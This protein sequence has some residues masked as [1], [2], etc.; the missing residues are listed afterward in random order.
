MPRLTYWAISRTPA[1]RLLRAPDPWR[2][3]RAGT[4]HPRVGVPTI[5]LGLLTLAGTLGALAAL[6]LLA[7]WLQ[8]AQSPDVTVQ[9]PLPQRLAAMRA[10]VADAEYWLGVQPRVT[11]VWGLKIAVS[12]QTPDPS[13]AL[14]DAEKIALLAPDQPYIEGDVKQIRQLYQRLQLQDALHAALAHWVQQLGG[15][16]APSTVA[17]ASSTPPYAQ[18]ASWLNM[19]LVEVQALA[20]PDPR[21]VPETVLGLR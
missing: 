13:R 20:E 4:H 8:T 14:R 7:L 2:V 17:G 21:S 9:S 3:R 1:Q 6:P 10:L 16:A 11:L 5:K 12:P 15:S 19:I 18:M